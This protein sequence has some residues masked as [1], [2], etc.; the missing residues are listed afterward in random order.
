MFVV[1][2]PNRRA[3]TDPNFTSPY[4]GD[5]QNGT[6]NYGKNPRGLQEAHVVGNMTPTGLLTQNLC[7]LFYELPSKP[8]NILTS[9]Q[10]TLIAIRP[11][12][13]PHY[14]GEQQVA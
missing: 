12:G 7:R 2:S 14:F 10:R 11:F 9:L 8:P 13:F 6:P 5:P 1:V 4:Y 3:N